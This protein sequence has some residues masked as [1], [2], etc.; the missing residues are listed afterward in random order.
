MYKKIF[1]AFLYVAIALL[2]YLFHEPLLDWVHNNDGEYVVLTTIIATTMSLFPVIPYPIVGGVIGAV[3]GSALGG[4]VTWLGSTF[5]SLIMFIF[6]RYWFQDIGVQLLHRYQ[7]LGKITLLFERNAFMTIF[8]TRLIPIIP[9][10]IINVYSAM[11]RI[12]FA[13]YA[14]ASSL[15]KIPA[16]ILFA[17]IGELVMTNP[18]D[19]LMTIGIYGSFLA[20]VY[21]GYRLWKKHVERTVVP[22]KSYESH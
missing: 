21:T 4:L 11:S 3:Y 17:V 9:S 8:V 22:T 19:I 13:A 5:A 12:G 6:V 10:I 15:G 20:V 16:M 2:I 14:I 7:T 18:T 1:V